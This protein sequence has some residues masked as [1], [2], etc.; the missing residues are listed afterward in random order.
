MWYVYIVEC[1]DRTLYT[2][3]A[4]D[5][6]KRIAMHNSGKGAKYTRSRLPVCLVYTEECGSQPEAMR[7]E[8][9][10]KLLSLRK[11]REL[12]KVYST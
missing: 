7:R 5:V 8:R 9:E 4:K 1:S 11:K 10:I 6:A 12:L 3:I 2:G